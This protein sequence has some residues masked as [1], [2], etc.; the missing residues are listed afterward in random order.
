ME[1]LLHFLEFQAADIILLQEV[2]DGTDQRLPRRYRSLETFLNQLSYPHHTFVA[3]Y[4]ETH[5]SGA[6]ARR[7]NAILSKFPIRKSDALFFDKPYS[8]TYVN[9]PRNA[10][11]CPRNIQYALVVVSRFSLIITAKRG[12]Y[13]A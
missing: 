11:N 9:A 10:H 1:E 7:G 4:L 3:D 8:E 13:G 5:H 6:L 12:C 2:Y